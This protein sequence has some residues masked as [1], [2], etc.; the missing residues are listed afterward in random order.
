MKENFIYLE[1]L[2]YIFTHTKEILV[3][4]N[5]FVEN[6]DNAMHFPHSILFN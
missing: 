4:I 3:Y 5:Q 2:I 1:V 6:I